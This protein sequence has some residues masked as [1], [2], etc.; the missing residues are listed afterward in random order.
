[1][2]DCKTCPR[3]GYEPITNYKILPFTENIEKACLF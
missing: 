3:L 1:M 2:L